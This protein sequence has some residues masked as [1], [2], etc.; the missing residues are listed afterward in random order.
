MSWSVTVT[1]DGQVYSL[2]VAHKVAYALA[3]TV[4]ILVCKTADSLELRI[5]PAE[6][7]EELTESSARELVVRSLNDFAL[8]EHMQRETAGLREL[9]AQ[10]ALKEA[11]L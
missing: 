5:S 9:L 7:S 8:R 1:L 10:A 2:Q 3:P 11:G 6:G 4:T